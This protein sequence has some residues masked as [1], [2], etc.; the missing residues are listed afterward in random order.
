MLQFRPHKIILLFAILVS[1]VSFAFSQAEHVV[2]VGSEHKVSVGVNI[3]STFQWGVYTNANGSVNALIINY[4]FKDA[5]SNTNSVDI[6]WNV[7]GIHYLVVTEL[8]GN[9]C[10]TRRA[11][12]V[13]VINT[14][15]IAFNTLSSDDCPDDDNSF[16]T[17]LVAKFD[18]DNELSEKQYPLTVN[19]RI[20]GDTEDR[21][22]TVNADKMLHVEGIIEN[23]DS[24]DIYDIS[25]ISVSNKYG[26]KLQVV[27]DSKVHSRTIYKKPVITG[28]ITVN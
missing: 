17:A 7:T 4:D 1:W 9:G 26:G 28:T 10:Q 5:I 8:G 27:V 11:V 16:A 18:S 23:E 25:I 14:P 21:I 13:N 19:Y 3:S 2:V 24:E 20:T 15:T 12:K 6:K 22:A